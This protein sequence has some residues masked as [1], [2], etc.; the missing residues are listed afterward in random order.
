MIASTYRLF[1]FDFDGTLADSGAW[2]VGALRQMAD[3]HGFRKPTDSEI[4]YLRGLSN[5][6]ILKWLEIPGWRLPFIARDM[7]KLAGMATV[8]LFPSTGKLLS[9]LAAQGV[10]LAIV[11]SNS[12]VNIERALGPSAGLFTHFECG[13]SLFGKGKRI[14]RVLQAT[15][16]PPAEVIVVGDEVRDVEAAASQGVASAAVTWGYARREALEAA[17]PTHLVETA[18]ELV[19]LARAKGQSRS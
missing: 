10:S 8:E 5:R 7:R 12:R 14:R 4:D 18:D 1:L 11:S 17:S 16:R 3:R 9:E 15:G 19:R 6:E 2:M 13:A